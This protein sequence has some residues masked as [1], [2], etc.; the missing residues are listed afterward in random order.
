MPTEMLQKNMDE[1]KSILIDNDCE[2]IS[3]EKGRQVKY[4]CSC[5]NIGET[6]YLNIRRKG[7]GG[8][9]KCSKQKCSQEIKNFI[10]ESDGYINLSQICKA[11]NKFYRDWFRLEKTKKFLTELSHE[12]KLDILTDK[13]IKGRSG[14]VVGLIEINQ[15]NDS[16]QSTW[17]H[18]YVAN[19]IAQWVSTK[20]SVKVSMWID[21]WKNISE[22][23][24]KKYVVS[25]ENIEPDNNSS[26]VEK[27]IQNRLYKE[28]GGE[29]EVHT[30]FGYIDLLT[31]TEL[32]E[33]KVGNNWKHGLGQLLAYRKFY[34]NHSLRLHLFDIE[35][36]TDISDWCKEY[37]V[38][39]TYEK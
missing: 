34:L 23:N 5:K 6:S 27:D 11:G 26:C 21:E 16:D 38:L 1:I 20:F 30:N 31:E 25:I 19:N 22:I 7:W 36:Q 32:I 24:S 2:L 9:A 33:I 37:N 12:L 14:Y 3:F 15:Y 29:M 13:T 4:T 28:L 35:H 17:G 8:C 18:P 10:R 39:V